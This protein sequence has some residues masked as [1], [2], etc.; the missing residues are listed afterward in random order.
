MNRV[1]QIDIKKLC[2]EG[3]KD[4]EVKD[5]KNA[6]R[7]TKKQEFSSSS[8]NGIMNEKHNKLIN[9]WRKFEEYGTNL[10]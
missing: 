3:E 7:S 1:L 10:T 6:V 5:H 4:E 8:E 2:V 9:I